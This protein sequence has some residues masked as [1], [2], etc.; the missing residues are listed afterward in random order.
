MGYNGK[1]VSRLTFA[2]IFLYT[3]V[4]S[5]MLKL[6]LR[7]DLA[8][9]RTLI[10]GCNR[11]TLI[12]F[13]IPLYNYILELVQLIVLSTEPPPHKDSTESLSHVTVERCSACSQPLGGFHLTPGLSNQ[14]RCNMPCVR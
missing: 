6:I 11:D 13:A 9:K 2:A 7:V 1:G 5:N 8:P 14:I 4:L 12:G 10:R 3:S